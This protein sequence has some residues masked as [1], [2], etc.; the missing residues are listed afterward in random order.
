MRCIVCLQTVWVE[1]LAVDTKQCGLCWQQC[2]VFVCHRLLCTA[3]LV[4]A[5]EEERTCQRI[6]EEPIYIPPEDPLPHS[7]KIYTPCCTNAALISIPLSS[8]HPVL[9]LTL[10]AAFYPP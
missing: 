5:R 7:D 4:C 6:T 8:E 3:V 9:N 1:T 2:S 10:I